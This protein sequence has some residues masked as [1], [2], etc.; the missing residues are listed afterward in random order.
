MGAG[1][2]FAGAE[3]PAGREDLASLRVG[4][5]SCGPDLEV[6]GPRLLLEIDLGGPLTSCAFAGVL[7]LGPEPDPAR[8][9]GAGGPCLGVELDEP[10]LPSG[11]VG[12]DD[13]YMSVEA[14]LAERAIDAELVGRSI[15]GMRNN[16]S[17][18]PSLAGFS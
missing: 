4:G 5:D 1:F 15:A 17:E 12:P 7:R 3:R 10:A 2:D 11:L 13:I 8:G 9:D 14:W 6:P 18:I 16:F